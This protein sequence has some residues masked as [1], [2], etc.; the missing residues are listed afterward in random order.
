MH[1]NN[2]KINQ[3]FKFRKIIKSR[4]IIMKIGNRC[5]ILE[6]VKIEMDGKVCDV[7]YD[8]IDIKEGI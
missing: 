7:L 2:T 6:Y 5:I 3:N 4:V 1:K 8:I